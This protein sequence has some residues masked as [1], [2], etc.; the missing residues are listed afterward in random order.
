MALKTVAFNAQLAR[1]GFYA[2][3]RQMFLPLL[4]Y[5]CMVGGDGQDQ[6]AGL[7]S[8][9]AEILRLSHIVKL[10]AKGIGLVVFD[11]FARSTNPFEGSRFV[12]ALCRF[13]QTQ[14]VY[15]LLATH[16]DGVNLS[17]AS[18]YQVMGLKKHD[19]QTTK[20]EDDPEKLLERLCQNMDYRLQKINQNYQVP[21]DALH[22]ARLL[23]ADENFL[24]IL[25]KYYE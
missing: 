25:Q 13:L 11:E 19:L 23:Q 14:K 6:K 16:Y 12:L 5:I 4:D 7:S 15:G 10:F 2:F 21:R 24:G 18:Y 1:L 17:G 3:A 20:I 9:G 22:I 8:F